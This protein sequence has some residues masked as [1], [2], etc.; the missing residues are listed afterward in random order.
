MLERD[1]AKAYPSCI[2]GAWAGPPKD[3]GGSGD[4]HAVL[5]RRRSA[6]LYRVF[7]GDEEDVADDDDLLAGFEPDR[8]SRREVN[9]GLRHEF[10][11]LRKQG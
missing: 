2:A 1:A 8:F 9:A 3:I 11:Q 4:Y 10:A 5:D 6:N 7:G